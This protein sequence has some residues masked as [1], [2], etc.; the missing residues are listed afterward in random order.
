MVNQ[1]VLLDTNFILTC[2]KQKIDFFEWFN[3]QG[4]KIIIPLEVINELKMLE[5]REKNKLSLHA[6]FAIRLLKQNNF[7]KIDLEG[8]DKADKVIVQFAKQNPKVIIATLDREMKEQIK[9]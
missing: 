9:C 4:I 1:K 3:L 8:G 6:K 5:G 7:K 2:I